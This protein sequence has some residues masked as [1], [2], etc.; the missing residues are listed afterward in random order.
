MEETEKYAEL[1]RLISLET[2]WQNVSD[3]VRVK[4]LVRYEYD[5][6][7]NCV[8]ETSIKIIAEQIDGEED[9]NE[10]WTYTKYCFNALVSLILTESYA[11]NE[12]D[13][14]G[15]NFEERV[16]ND[17]GNVVKCIRWNSLDSSSKFYEEYD[18]A[19]NG[20]VTADR[21]ETG[22]VSAEYEYLSGTNL[23]HYRQLTMV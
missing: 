8:K 13:I 6:H 1:D 22:E 7:N 20:Q 3:T 10:K 23:V 16:Y 5:D 15:V 17:D 21:Y 11:E 14:S 19:E 18:R 2:S 4:K 9:I 12:E